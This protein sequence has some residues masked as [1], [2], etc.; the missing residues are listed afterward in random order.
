MIACERTVLQW[1]NEMVTRWAG[2]LTGDRCV[3]VAVVLDNCRSI[4]VGVDVSV[5][6]MRV[7]RVG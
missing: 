4:A 7:G 1:A 5:L 6:R 2:A 3:L